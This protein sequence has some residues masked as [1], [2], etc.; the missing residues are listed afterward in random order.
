MQAGLIAA[1]LSLEV[2]EAAVQK[3]FETNVFSIFHFIQAVVPCFHAQGGG[4][5]VNI[6]SDTVLR[7]S[8]GLT[9]FSASKGAVE[10]LTRSLA[11]EFAADNIRVCGVAPVLGIT[12]N[13]KKIFGVDMPEKHAAFLATIPLGRLAHPADI[14]AA[15]CF[16]GSDAA[17]MITGQI[18]TVDGGRWL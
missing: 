9:W 3:V 2:D 17:A 6:S 13:L 11:L 1:Y 15:V 16:L 12:A 5:I 14:A 18:L 10:A 4:V 7:P 8:T